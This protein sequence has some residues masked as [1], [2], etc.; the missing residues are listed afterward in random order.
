ML[1]KFK[2]SHPQRRII[3]TELLNPGTG[4]ANIAWQV[5][6][7][8]TVEKE[9]VAIFFRELEF[10]S[11]QNRFLNVLEGGKVMTNDELRTTNEK[12]DNNNKERE[13]ITAEEQIKITKKF[14]E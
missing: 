4:F 14:G 7:G 10:K 11:L 1:K 5:K 9:K 6:L 8:E 13:E 3:F 2:L 12:K